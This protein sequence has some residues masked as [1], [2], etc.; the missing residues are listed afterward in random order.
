MHFKIS[1]TTCRANL[2]S[3]GIQE[4]NQTCQ[5]KKLDKP[6]LCTVCLLLI[7][8]SRFFIIFYLPSKFPL[9]LGGN[10]SWTLGG[11]DAHVSTHS[12]SLPE[13]NEIY[14]DMR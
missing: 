5:M 6:I 7:S 3:E 4:G 10:L 1:R 14:S 12:G 8:R 13:T 9:S 2:N 11:R